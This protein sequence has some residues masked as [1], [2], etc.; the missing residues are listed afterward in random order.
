L[1]FKSVESYVFP[2]THL[3]LV[4]FGLVAPAF[5]EWRTVDALWTFKERSSLKGETILSL[6]G[7]FMPPL[8]L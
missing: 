8:G 4:P 2:P 1:Y 6:D 7:D 3:F 5:G